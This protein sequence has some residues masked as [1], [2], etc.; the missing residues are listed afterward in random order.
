MPVVSCSLNP[1]LI[2]SRIFLRILRN[3]MV[4]VVSLKKTQTCSC[5][6]KGP[7]HTVKTAVHSWSWIPELKQQQWAVLTRSNVMAEYVHKVQFWNLRKTLD[8]SLTC[9][10]INVLKS[11]CPI[12]REGTGASQYNQNGPKPTYSKG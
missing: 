9:Y 1:H 6:I 5:G 2:S 4:M 10:I 8:T 7:L 12:S 11:I 3:V